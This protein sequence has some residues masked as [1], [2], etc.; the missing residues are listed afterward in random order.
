MLLAAKGLKKGP[1]S[2]ANTMARRGVKF[3]C[4]WSGFMGLCGPRD[5]FR[6]PVGIERSLTVPMAGG[7]VE[8][9]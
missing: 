1:V 2:E 3:M 9:V 7:A 4:S 6:P 8:T 5:E